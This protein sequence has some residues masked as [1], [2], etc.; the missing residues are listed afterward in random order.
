[1]LSSPQLITKL[2]GGNPDIDPSSL[3]TDFF[4]GKDT[5]TGY[6]RIHNTHGPNK[7]KC[8]IASCWQG[9]EKGK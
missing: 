3:K 7:L 2:S 5:S 6:D 8:Y 9:F 4:A 1:M